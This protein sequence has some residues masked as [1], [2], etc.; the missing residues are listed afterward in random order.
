VFAA[1]VELEHQRLAVAQPQRGLEALGQPLALVGGFVWC[2]RCAQT[3]FGRAHL[4]AVDHH[5]EVVFALALECRQALG[6][7]HLAVE[8][9]AHEA[10]RLQLGQ[11]V[12]KL[13]LAGARD[14]GQQQDFAPR[15]QRQHLID[16]LA[17]GLRPQRLAVLG[18]VRAADAG[19]EQPQVVVDFGHRAHGR[20][21]VVAGGFLLDG[22]GRRQAVDAVHVGLVEALQKLARVGAQALDVAALALGVQGVEGEAGF[23]RTRQPGDH[24]QRVFRDVEVDVFQVVRARATHAQH[25]QRSRLA[26]RLRQRQAIVGRRGCGDA[27]GK[28]SSG[29]GGVGVQGATRSG[30][31]P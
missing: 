15:R 28:G 22:D 4:E 6:L 19:V 27:G 31:N 10:L 14:R 7:E 18:A 9:E 29:G 11:G 26:Q 20:A 25:R 5:V 12:G 17:H 1:A 30:A 3:G 13:A 21:R 16:H 23:A 2:G 8:P 24:H